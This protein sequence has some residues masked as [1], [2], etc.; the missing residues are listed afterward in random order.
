MH[1]MLLLVQIKHCGNEY[2]KIGVSKTT[3]VVQ[4]KALNPELI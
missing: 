4:H 1:H 3:H 2:W